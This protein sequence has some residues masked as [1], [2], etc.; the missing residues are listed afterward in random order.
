EL[1]QLNDGLVLGG[2]TL[3][4][5]NPAR[6]AWFRLR[7]TVQVNKP[8]LITMTS[9]QR[10]SIY[11]DGVLVKTDEFRFLRSNFVGKMVLGTS[12]SFDQGWVGQVRGLSLFDREIA[13]DEVALRYRSWMNGQVQASGA[14]HFYRFDEHNGQIVKDAVSPGINLKIP[15]RYTVIDGAF[16][17][18]PW[19]GFNNDW[20]YWKDVLVNIGGFIPFGFLFGVYFSSVNPVQRPLL[21]T[22]LFGGLVT[23]FIETT[24]AWLPTRDSSM[25]DV[26]TNILGTA[27]GAVLQSSKP[28]RWL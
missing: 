22:I 24:Q 17:E 27:I 15:P 1:L 6:I 5:E 8:I 20:G 12:P 13:A 9:G 18:S 10:T 16:L 26:L 2:N 28:I 4:Q 7:H 21:T 3:S 11:I 23:L 14:S 19:K 25:T